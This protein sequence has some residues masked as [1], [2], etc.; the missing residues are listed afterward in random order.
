MASISVA[1][2]SCLAPEKLLSSIIGVV[3]PVLGIFVTYSSDVIGHFAYFTRFLCTSIRTVCW[4]WPTYPHL[5]Q[6]SLN[7]Q[8]RD[9]WWSLSLHFRSIAA[10]MAS[11]FS[12]LLSTVFSETFFAA[13]VYS[14][15]SQR[16]HFELTPAL[17]L[18]LS[19]FKTMT[20]FGF[21][22]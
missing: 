19:D 9:H 12:T 14:W 1:A 20:S 17:L 7:L 10:K 22:I 11:Y 3:S 8:S 15:I 4:M 16:L 18:A 21:F 6:F 13:F 5:W 2:I